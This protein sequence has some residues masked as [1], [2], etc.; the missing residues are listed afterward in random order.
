MDWFIRMI[1]KSKYRNILIYRVMEECDIQSVQI[2]N[3]ENFHIS[4][5]YIK[6]LVVY[7]SSNVNIHHNEIHKCKINKPSL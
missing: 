4:D 5:S 1:L 2:V 6:E 7:K 3:G